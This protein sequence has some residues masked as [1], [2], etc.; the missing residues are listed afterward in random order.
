MRLFENRYIGL[1][2]LW[3]AIRQAFRLFVMYIRARCI[4][5]ETLDSFQKPLLA[6]N[7][8][9][10]SHS[11]TA[12]S[13]NSSYVSSDSKPVISWILELDCLQFVRS[14]VQISPF[15]NAVTKILHHPKD[16]ILIFKEW[17]YRFHLLSHQSFHA[18]GPSKLAS[19][20]SAGQDLW[21]HLRTGINRR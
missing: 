19:V 6:I 16:L 11:T 7:V 13:D 12:S 17:K 5:Q 20:S 18:E 14:L 4:Q 8:I 21:S 3:W 2:G 1:P 9:L 15:C 10:L